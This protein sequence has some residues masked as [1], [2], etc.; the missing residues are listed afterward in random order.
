MRV[1]GPDRSVCGDVEGSARFGVG[2][3]GGDMADSR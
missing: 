3:V 1:A 2:N